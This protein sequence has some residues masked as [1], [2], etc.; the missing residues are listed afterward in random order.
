VASHDPPLVADRSWSPCYRPSS[1]TPAFA[2]YRTVLSIHFD[3]WRWASLGHRCV[4]PAADLCW[5]LLPPPAPRAGVP[6]A[7]QAIKA[8]KF[9]SASFARHGSLRMNPSP[10][11]A[12]C[13]PPCQSEPPTRLGTF[14]VLSSSRFF[15]FLSRPPLPSR[16]HQGTTPSV[17][18]AILCPLG[19]DGGRRGLG[20]RR[21]HG[22]RRRRH[23]RLHGPPP[24]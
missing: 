4:P 19:G 23:T 20:H 17:H 15:P 21:L 11:P 13:L 24:C 2:P 16:Y 9:W 14:V 5:Q 8:Q 6:G 1:V 22:G 7:A 3:A 18:H 12:V 10:T